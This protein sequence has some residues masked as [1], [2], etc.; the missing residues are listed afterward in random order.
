MIN[1]SR[2]ALTTA[3]PREPRGRWA[4]LAAGT[5]IAALAMAAYPAARQGQESRATQTVSFDFLVVKK[6]G[7]PVTD[8]KLDEVTLRIDNKTRPIKSLQYIPLS[9]GMGGVAALDAS[10]ASPIAP[11]FAT[12]LMATATTPRSIVIIVDDESMPIGQEIKL[13]AALNSFVQNLPPADPVA[14]VT[15]PHGG[16]KVGFTTNRDRLAKGISEISPIVPIASAPC[17]TKD[18]LST[19]ETTLGLLTRNSDQPVAVA[20]LSSALSG[21]S[22]A[23]AAQRPTAGGGGGVGDQAG[24]CHIVADNFVRVGQAVAAAKA[25]LYVIH[26]DYAPTPV[27]E[28]IESL[29]AQTGAPLFHLTSSG[30]PGLTRMARET[31]GYYLATFETQPD[32]LTGKPHPSSVKVSRPDVDV[33]DKPY[34]IVGRANAAPAPTASTTTPTITTAFDMVRSGRAFR[35]LPLR[36]T[37]SV[38]RN[39]KDKAA[40]DVI[41]WFEPIDASVKVMTAAAALIDEN[42]NAQAYWQSEPDQVMTWPMAI[43]LTVRPGTYRLRVGAIDASGRTGLV[44]DKLVVAMQQAGPLRVGGLILGLSRAGGFAPRLQFSTEAAAIAYVELYGTITEEMKVSVV[45]E[46]ARTTD[47]PAIMTAN[48]TASATNEDD[49]VGVTGTIPVGALEP[50]DYVVRAVVT[51]AGQGS[52]R[53]LRTL[54]KSS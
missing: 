6:D 44:D 18:M 7:Q 17:Q 23:E 14:L 47:G 12:N 25:Q 29:R 27:W 21:Q 16:I 8:L 20:F 26:P 28:G 13:R 2:T 52:A 15:V 4:T 30:E 54:R 40:V 11:P 33:R 50:G 3:T 46:V 48:A 22:Q 5:V 38:S 36:A 39:S 9:S 43:G 49:K 37:A 34:L 1:R 53:V 31:A 41:G 32:E 10:A 35:D 24:G 45:F 51:V 19:L 42:G